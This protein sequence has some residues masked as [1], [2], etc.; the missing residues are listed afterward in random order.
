MA[1]TPK[2]RIERMAEEKAAITADIAEI[3]AEAKGLGFDPKIMK[4]VVKIRKMDHS[5]RIE[6][7]TVLGLYLS[8]LGMGGDE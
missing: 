7:E 1:S 3:Y 4:M 2:A 8:A 6:Q 5:A